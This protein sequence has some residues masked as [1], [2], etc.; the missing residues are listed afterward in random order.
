MTADTLT[1]ALR[2]EFH[3]NDLG[4]NITVAGYLQRLLTDLWQQEDMFNSKR[5]FG[6]SGW[7]WEVYGA[8]IEARLIPGT[9]DEDGCIEDFDEPQ[10][11]AFM[12]RVI[13]H[14]FQPP[15]QAD[16]ADGAGGAEAGGAR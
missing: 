1:A 13:A 10:A 4:Q 2:L 11:R 6:N 5:P 15:A 9:L 7:T 14:L 12:A 16:A 8:L 3:S